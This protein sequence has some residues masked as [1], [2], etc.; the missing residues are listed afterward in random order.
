MNLSIANR[1]SIQMLIV[2]IRL[3]LAMS[4]TE[5]KHMRWLSI[6]IDSKTGQLCELAIHTAPYTKHSCDNSHTHIQKG[7]VFFQ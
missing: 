2:Y 4:M 5:T 1:T 3:L 7:Y 6:N